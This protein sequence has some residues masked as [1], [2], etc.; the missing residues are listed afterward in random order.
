MLRFLADA[1]WG[2]HH[3]QPQTPLRAIRFA[4]TCRR[5]LRGKRMTWSEF[6]ECVRG[7]E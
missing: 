5:T 2:W 7:G 3:L 6:W 1:F 4:R